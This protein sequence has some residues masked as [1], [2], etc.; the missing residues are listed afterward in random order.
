MTSESDVTTTRLLKTR[1]R[2]LREERLIFVGKMEHNN[3]GRRS[4]GGGRGGRGGR[5]GAKNPHAPHMLAN[6]GPKRYY[7]QSM[8]HSTKN[9]SSFPCNFFCGWITACFH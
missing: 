1:F 5:G 6:V 3:A 7:S 4:F 2:L 9:K 8:H